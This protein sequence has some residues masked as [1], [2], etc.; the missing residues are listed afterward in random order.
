MPHCTIE[1]SRNLEKQLSPETL[2]TAVHE[3]AMDSGLFD[4]SAIKIRCAPYDNV[5]VGGNEQGSFLHVMARIL[6]GRT[7]EQKTKL[8]HE[9]YK[10]LQQLELTVDAL[11]VEICDIDRVSHQPCPD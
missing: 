3:G 5:S 8:S 4:P 7:A 11:T 2:L 10:Q 6:S 9:I 1:Y